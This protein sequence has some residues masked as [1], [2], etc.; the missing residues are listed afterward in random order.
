MWLD[1]IGLGKGVGVLLLPWGGG[2]QELGSDALSDC[3]SRLC[4]L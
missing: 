1:G 3:I 4:L 2:V